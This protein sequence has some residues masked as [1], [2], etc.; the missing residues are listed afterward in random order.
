MQRTIC[1]LSRLHYSATRLCLSVIDTSFIRGGAQ[2]RHLKFNRILQPFSSST[3][4]SQSD[5][6]SASQVSKDDSDLLSRCHPYGIT[7]TLELDKESDFDFKPEDYKRLADTYPYRQDLNFWNILLDYRVRQ[8]GS[9]GALTIW[10]GLKYR[11][12]RVSLESEDDLTTF[13]WQKL[14]KMI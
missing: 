3:K 10:R 8:Y 2:C 1:G 6:D 4:V 14:L 5:V 12:T 13:F 9:K 7:S 11:G